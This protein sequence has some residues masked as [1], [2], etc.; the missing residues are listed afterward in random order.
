MFKSIEVSRLVSEEQQKAYLVVQIDLPPSTLHF[1]AVWS[2]PP[3]VYVLYYF[4]YNL[5]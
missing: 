4:H 2:Y 5:G 3:D 1:Q